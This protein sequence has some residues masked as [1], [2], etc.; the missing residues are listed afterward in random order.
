MPRSRAEKAAEDAL[1][2]VGLSSAAQRPTRTYSRGMRQRA[3][4]AQALAHRPE[5]LILDEPL[6]GADP[7]ARVQILRTISEFAKA[8]GH[9]LMSTHVLYEIERV[10]NN[11]VLINNG[12]AIAAGDIHSIRALIDEHPR[13]APRDAA[14][15]TAR[16]GP[17]PDG[18]YRLVGDSRRGR[19]A[20][21]DPQAR[22]LLPRAPCDRGRHP[23]GGP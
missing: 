4:L 16:A 3:K 21:P 8:G 10:T 15:A 7:L 23:A 9:V 22:C 5:I 20:R 14:A 6:S 2:L 18:A 1:K 13:G 17:R 12:K 11:I 19:P